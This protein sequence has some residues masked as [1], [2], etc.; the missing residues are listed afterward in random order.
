MYKLI[1]LDLDGTLLNSQRSISPENQ[2]AIAAARANGVKVVLV[3]GRP[4]E[5]MLDHVNTLK[6]K[7]NDDYILSYNASLI[8]NSKSKKVIHKEVLTG[9]DAKYIADLA[10]E[11]GVNVHA[12][13]P[14][15]GLITPISSQ[16]T[17]RESEVNGM[18]ISLF[19]FEDL[20]D[21][22]EILKT[23]VVADSDK[24]T[25]FENQLTAE[26][27]ERYTIMRSTPFFLEFLSKKSNKG[28]GVKALACHLNIKPE[29]VICMGDAGNDA[30]MIEYAG[31]GVAMGN[32]TEDIK[33][34]AQYITT[35]NND[36]GVAK[37]INE[38]V[39]DLKS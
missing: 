23:M 2:Q 27:Y 19:N 5:G 16:Y 14:Q 33:D 29:E 15:D 36:H 9:K 13:T 18:P 3:S 22:A 21:G 25:E 28:I 32:A 35:S 38:F 37:V 17:E 30:H 12:F 7:S 26:L 6:M 10:T 31:L 11:F 20:L 4:T 1:A 39:L 34:L 8:Q 24:L